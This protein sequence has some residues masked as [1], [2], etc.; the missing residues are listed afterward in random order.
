MALCST[1]LEMANIHP[2]QSTR[3]VHRCLANSAVILFGQAGP[4]KWMC[5]PNRESAT[6][7]L[8][9]LY[10]RNQIELPDETV[11]LLFSANRWEVS[12]DIVDLLSAG[13][14]LV[15]D[16][17]A[18]S[19]VAY[20]AAKGLDFTWCQVRLVPVTSPTTSPPHHHRL[21]HTH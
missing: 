4:V 21:R 9:D 7:T 18:F 2:L 20:S 19:G 13:T 12:R 1:R 16:R 6:G 5:F 14:C 3:A 17:Y 11:H 10:L 8:I 15:C